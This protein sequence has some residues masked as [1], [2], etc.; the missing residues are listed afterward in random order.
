MAPRLARFAVSLSLLL[1]P[2]EAAF[3][4]GSSQASEGNHASTETKKPAKPKPAKPD[5]E[6]NCQWARDDALE[7][8][9]TPI[10][11]SQV[12]LK[13]VLQGAPRTVDGHDLFADSARMILYIRTPEGFWYSGDMMRIGSVDEGCVSHYVSRIQPLKEDPHL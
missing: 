6:K 13:A 4:N 8:G 1:G 9:G 2:P 5:K 3:A 10:T 11:V 7:V 12:V